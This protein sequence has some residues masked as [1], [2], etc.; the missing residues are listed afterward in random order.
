MPMRDATWEA[1][2]IAADALHV[3]NESQVAVMSHRI[4]ESLLEE[5]HSS[6]IEIKAT[7]PCLTEEEADLEPATRMIP[8]HCVRHCRHHLSK[9]RAWQQLIQAIR[10][11]DRPAMT[12]PVRQLKAWL[13]APAPRSWTSTCGC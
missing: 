2:R 5:F 4:L 11:Q 8:H 3:L 7:K 6:P 13:G 12:D 1:R 10:A 9:L